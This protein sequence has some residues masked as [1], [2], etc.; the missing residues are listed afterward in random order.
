MLYVLFSNCLTF[1]LMLCWNGVIFGFSRNKA[2]MLEIGPWNQCDSVSSHGSGSCFR[3]KSSSQFRILL[4]DSLCLY[5][6][7]FMDVNMYPCCCYFSDQFILFNFNNNISY[8]NSIQLLFIQQLYNKNCQSRYPTA[9]T[10]FLYTVYSV[11]RRR[12]SIWQGTC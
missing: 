8:H 3:I 9:I 6:R 11:Y 12:V 4:T 7:Q 2:S 5:D 10:M 1:C